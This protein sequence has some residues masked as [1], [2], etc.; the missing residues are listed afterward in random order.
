MGISS[1]KRHKKEGTEVLAEDL[2]FMRRNLSDIDRDHDQSKQH[3][4]EER[5]PVEFPE[6][7][8]SKGKWEQER[9]RGGRPHMRPG[10]R[11]NNGS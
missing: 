10:R 11:G 2:Q 7:E 5:K 4:A 1:A 3:P 6:W 9:V 8:N